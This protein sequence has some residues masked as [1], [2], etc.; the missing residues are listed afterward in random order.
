MFLGI[1]GDFFTF[2]DEYQ[3]FDVAAG[4]YHTGKSYFWDFHQQALSGERYTRAWPH[5][6]LLSLWFRIFGVTVAA[7]NPTVIDV[8]SADQDAGTYRVFSPTAADRNKEVLEKE[9][10]YTYAETVEN[11]IRDLD[12]ILLNKN[13]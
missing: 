9:E 13:R 2:L 1:G 4:F 10:L 7:L 8:V 11:R 6:L 3:S 5:T 12:K